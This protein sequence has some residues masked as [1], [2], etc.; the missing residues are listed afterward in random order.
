MWRS[1]H[2]ASGRV[3]GRR[4]FFGATLKLA[5]FAFTVSAL[6]SCKPPAEPSFEDP[7]NSGRPS[8]SQLP[9]ITKPQ[10]TTPLISGPMPSPSISTGDTPEV[11][12]VYPAL[13]FQGAGTTS[14]VEALRTSATID[15]SLDAAKLSVRYSSVHVDC[16]RQSGPFGIGSCDQQKFDKQVQASVLGN[17]EFQRA[18]PAQ[19]RA[20]GIKQAAYAIFAMAVTVG[21]STYT[22]DKPLPVFPFPVKPAQ[23]S[24]LNQGPLTWSAAVSGPKESMSATVSISRLSATPSEIVLQFDLTLNGNRIDHK[25]YDKFPLPV[26]ATYHLSPNTQDLRAARTTLFFEDDHC[27]NAGTILL[28]YSLCRKV[29]GTLTERLGC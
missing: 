7:K 12:I 17:I 29:K 5:F 16:Y 3:S 8:P 10:N 6:P 15:T 21:T 22:F 18:T 26:Q 19:I 9:A 28:D 11:A 14:C 25:A 20:A 2:L 23:L 27:P 24:D 1:S 4:G 13:T